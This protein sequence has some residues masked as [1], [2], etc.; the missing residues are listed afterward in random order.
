MQQNTAHETPIEGRPGTLNL[1]GTAGAW[2]SGFIASRRRLSAALV[3][4]V[5]FLA[6]YN[7]VINLLPQGV[8]DS[9]YVPLNLSVG[10]LLVLWAR[11]CGL[12]W[13]DLG[14]SSAS[15]Q[16]GA[17][18]GLLLGIALPS[19]LFLALV[20][21]DPIPSLL[22]DPRLEGVTLAGLAYRGLVRIPLG[23]ALF[24]EVAL[25]GV[26]YGVWL[27]T[28]NLRSAVLGF[29]LL[30]ALWHIVPTFNVMQDSEHFDRPEWILMGVLGGIM[31]TLLGGLFFAWLRY[32]TGGIYGP[33][34]TH[35]LINALAATAAFVATRYL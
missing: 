16:S 10:L 25:R 11:W 6:L 2:A 5:V 1:V 9:L 3:T 17:I 31:A 8:H 33:F 13:K 20:F 19:V 12:S 32:R 14:L 30:F 22:D 29:S 28:S 18:W 23:T 15:L 7:N 27:K 24:E 21:P 4:L 26:L 35:W 34:L